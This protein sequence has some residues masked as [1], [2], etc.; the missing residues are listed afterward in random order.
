MQGVDYEGASAEYFYF[1]AKMALL[2]ALA[3]RAAT[4]GLA[5]TT[6]AS[7]SVTKAGAQDAAALRGRASLAAKPSKVV[8]S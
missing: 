3:S 4:K 6:R 1:L 7:A 2:A 8:D 5:E